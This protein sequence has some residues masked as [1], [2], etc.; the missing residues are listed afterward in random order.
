MKQK[1]TNIFWGILLIA[2]GSLIA[3]KN[4]GVINFQWLNFINLW[5]FLLI[6]G[7]IAVLPV[8][9]VN[10]KIVKQQAYPS[11]PELTSWIAASVTQ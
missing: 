5:P 2:L 11:Y 9:M 3:L 8:S 1:I 10:G 7:G 4:F 6:F